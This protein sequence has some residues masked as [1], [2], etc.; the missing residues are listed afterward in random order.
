MDRLTD[1]IIPAH[2]NWNGRDLYG[3]NKLNNSEYAPVYGT[4]VC[5]FSDIVTMEV[6]NGSRL[7]VDVGQYRGNI[8]RL[9]FDNGPSVTL[10]YN[11]TV[12]YES[13]NSSYISAVQNFFASNIGNICT[14]TISF[15]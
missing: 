13:Y 4:L 5:Q 9:S 15:S 6:I 11:G 2:V 10:S 14:F 8:M 1:Y 3:A 12:W 7:F